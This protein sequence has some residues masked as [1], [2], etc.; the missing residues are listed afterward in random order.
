[1]ARNKVVFSYS[2]LSLLTLH[3]NEGQAL[4]KENFSIS[5][6]NFRIDGQTI[7]HKVSQDYNQLKMMLQSFKEEGSNFGNLL[8]L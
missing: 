8:L 6:Y 1:M 7:L 2:Y 5:A 4:T 3:Q